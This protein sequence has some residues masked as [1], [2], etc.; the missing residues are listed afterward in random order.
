MTD[1]CTINHALVPSQYERKHIL[2]WNSAQVESFAAIYGR[3]WDGVCAQSNCTVTAPV[4][5]GVEAIAL[6]LNVIM[7]KVFNQISFQNH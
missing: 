2:L 1:V 4:S 3:N 7:F 5:S 6:D